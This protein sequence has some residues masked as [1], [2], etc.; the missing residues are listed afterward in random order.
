MKR[1]LNLQVWAILLA[2]IAMTMLLSIVNWLYS[3]GRAGN[4]NERNEISLELHWL[5]LFGLLMSKGILLNL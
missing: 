2:S 4:S 3:R 1:L 5:F